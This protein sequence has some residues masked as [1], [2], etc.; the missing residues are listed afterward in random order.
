[1]DQSSQ[2]C[3]YF[4]RGHH[5][6]HLVTGP[7]TLALQGDDALPEGGHRRRP[8]AGIG[9][10]TPLLGARVPAAA[11]AGQAVRGEGA[12]ADLREGGPASPAGSEE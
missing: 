8:A 12:A 9:G 10:G 11:V 3:V 5:F 1:M 7:H 2:H 4:W 6:N